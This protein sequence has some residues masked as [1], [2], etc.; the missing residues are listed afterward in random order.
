MCSED[1]DQGNNSEITWQ[2]QR[3][4]SPPTKKT[5]KESRDHRPELSD[6]TWGSGN[7]WYIPGNLSLKV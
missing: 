2:L 6:W 1:K 5:N 3:A 7:G 4:A